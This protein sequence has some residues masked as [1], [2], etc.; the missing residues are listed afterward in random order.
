MDSV[1]LWIVWKAPKVIKSEI[2]GSKI[3]TKISC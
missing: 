1:I 3:A 2:K